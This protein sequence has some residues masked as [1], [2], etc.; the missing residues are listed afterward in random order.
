[1]AEETFETYTVESEGITVSR[2]VWNRFMR[3]MRGLVERVLDIN[4]GIADF[5]TLPVGMAVTLP[6]PSM[7]E[8]IREPIAL[9]D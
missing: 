7:K 1:M 4:P 8:P 9:W 6:I 5:E 3:P 2:L